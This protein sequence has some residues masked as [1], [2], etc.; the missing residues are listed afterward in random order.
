[1]SDSNIQDAVQRTV[2]SAASFERIRLGPGVLGY[3]AYVSIFAVVALSPVA[4]WGGDRAPWALAGIILI[5][6]IFMA[7]AAWFG[8]NYPGP[9]LLGGGHLV[10]WRQMD[11]AAMNTPAVEGATPI[12]NPALAPPTEGQNV[13]DE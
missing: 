6:I 8:S 1:M 5:F 9:A 11:L 7:F 2:G 12:Q 4:L 13:S 3:A 10:Q